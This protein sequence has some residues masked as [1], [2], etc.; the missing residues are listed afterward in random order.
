MHLVRRVEKKHNAAEIFYNVGESSFPL[1]TWQPLA[2]WLLSPNGFT[3][4]ITKRVRKRLTRAGE[5]VTHTRFVVNFR[6]PRTGR[7]KQ[8]FF[9]RQRDAIAMRDA[10]LASVATGTYATAST[11]FTVQRAIQYWLDNRRMEVKRTTWVNYR[12]VARYITGPLL[13]GTR[14]QRRAFAETGVAPRGAQI[15]DMLGCT[16]IADLAT[17][18]IRRWHKVISSEVSIYSANVAKKY[19]RAALALVAEDFQVRVS[20]MPSRLGHGRSKPKKTIL[21][22]DQVGI[23]LRGAMNDG[24]RGIYYAFPFLTGVRSSEMLAL[25][26]DDVD[27]EKGVI[28][29]RRMQENDGSISSFGKTPASSRT[30]PIS[31]LLRSL[32]VRW[33]ATCPRK[34]DEPARVFPALGTKLGGALSYANFRTGYWAPALAELALPYVTPHSARH[35]FIST[36]QAKGVEVGLVAKLAG[37]ANALVT[38]SHYTHAMRGGEEALKELEDAYTVGT[39]SGSH[40]GRAGARTTSSLP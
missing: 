5:L 23:L 18:D 6:E 31:S 35:S 30:I 39:P 9:A 24:K 27:L 13:I 20:P 10:L 34:A 22:P 32:L 38:I 26:W 4:S 8:L 17:A 25:L 3:A 28:S 1:H 14:Q 2:R 37:H 11:S 15:I 36:L 12:Q 16:P 33:L 19:L 29:I 7:R 40:T 21:M